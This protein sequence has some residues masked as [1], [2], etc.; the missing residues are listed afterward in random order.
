MATREMAP[1]LRMFRLDHRAIGL[2]C[3][4]PQ[5]RVAVHQALLL[6]L[7]H[8]EGEDDPVDILVAVW[9]SLPIRVEEAL[10]AQDHHSQDQLVRRWRAQG[11]VQ[12]ARRAQELVVDGD[13]I[14]A[15]ALRM[16]R[17]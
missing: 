7:Q 1:M 15:M 10:G 6:R 3:S 17:A 11:V 8:R 14:R 13:L 2:G 5:H 12:T 16:D 4:R 9:L